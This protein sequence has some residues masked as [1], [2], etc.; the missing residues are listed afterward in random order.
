MPPIPYITCSQ[1]VPDKDSVPGPKAKNNPKV[2]LPERTAAHTQPRTHAEVGP[3]HTG[4]NPQRQQQQ[5]GRGP[6]ILSGFRRLVRIRGRGRGRGDDEGDE[7]DEE[8]P[9]SEGD[10]KPKR[11][12]LRRIPGGVLSNDGL[13][14]RDSLW[15]NNDQEMDDTITPTLVQLPWH[16]RMI[17]EKDDLNTIAVHLASFRRNL[18]DCGVDFA[19]NHRPLCFIDDHDRDGKWLKYTDS[20]KRNGHHLHNLYFHVGEQNWATLCVTREHHLTGSVWHYWALAVIAAP[21]QSPVQTRHDA[22]MHLLMYDSKPAPEPRYQRHRDYFVNYL[23]GEQEALLMA[24][25]EKFRVL[26]FAI[27]RD[28]IPVQGEYDPLRF[29]MWWIWAVARYGGRDYLREEHDGEDLDDPRWRLAN[30]RHM[31]LT[32]N[33]LRTIEAR[34]RGTNIRRMWS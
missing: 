21:R 7:G 2:S 1:H 24:F 9:P 17:N 14:M 19:V 22:G 6:R 15:G 10:R 8:I 34:L 23:S 31:D 12:E 20:D 26:T 3:S 18:K 16:I 32:P 5:P 27:N 33:R 28:Q 4:P 30:S 25:L 29:T 11:V 13:P